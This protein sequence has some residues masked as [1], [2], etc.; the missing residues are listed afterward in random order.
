M[1]LKG[2][3]IKK[4][5]FYVFKKIRKTLKL[6]L[7]QMLFNKIF[8]GHLSQTVFKSTGFVHKEIINLEFIFIGI[9]D[10]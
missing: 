6:Y 8:K 5:L 10:L 3:I 9:L 7:E 4:I 2:I 1:K